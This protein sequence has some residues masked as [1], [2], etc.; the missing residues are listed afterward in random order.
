MGRAGILRPDSRVELIEGELIDMAPIGSH[1]ASV[2]AELTMLF[3][4]QVGDE[5]LVW[6]QNPMAAPPKSELQPDITLLRPTQHRYRDS[7]PTADDVLLLVEVAETTLQYDRKV[8]LPLYAR[9][10]VR[11][12]WIVNLPER[13]LEIYREPHNGAYRIR[14]QCSAADVASPAALPRIS[15]KLSEW[16][17]G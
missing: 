10:G 6:T 2:V 1:H 16:F 3:S 4:R 5:A 11:E 8:K 7:L 9:H 12:V 17:A 13:V 14:Q 15:V